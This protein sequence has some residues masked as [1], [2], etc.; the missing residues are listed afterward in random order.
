M[1]LAIAAIKVKSVFSKITW[2][3]H[4]IKN[5]KIMFNETLD[6]VINGHLLLSGNTTGVVPLIF[7]QLT[8]KLS[9]KQN[10]FVDMY[11]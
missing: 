8:T 11:E 5:T 7:M 9:H 1:F 2:M 4:L 3:I 10:S 6:L